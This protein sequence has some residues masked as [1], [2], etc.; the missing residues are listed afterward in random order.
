[1]T[2]SRGAAFYR[3]THTACIAVDVGLFRVAT[4]EEATVI[5]DVIGVPK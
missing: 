4:P 5:L 1:M 2:Y 3:L